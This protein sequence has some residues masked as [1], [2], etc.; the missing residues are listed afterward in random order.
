MTDGYSRVAALRDIPETPDWWTFLSCGTDGHSRVAGQMDIPELRDRWTFHICGTDGH[1][2]V[3]GPMD[4]PEL[5]DLWIFQSCVFSI[6]VLT[7]F[8]PSNTATLMRQRF[9]S[10]NDAIVQDS[11]PNAF[12][13]WIQNSIVGDMTFFL[14]LLPVVIMM[15]LVA[16]VL[17]G[18]MSS[19]LFREARWLYT[20][21][22]ICRLLFLFRQKS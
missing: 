8:S 6:Y 13:S 14:P 10:I 19:H 9:C 2:R 3:A 17:M 11:I 21:C 1:S 22:Q 16:T 20:W 4:H 18:M 5:K 7:S 12:N 15:M